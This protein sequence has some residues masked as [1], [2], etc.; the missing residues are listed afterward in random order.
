MATWPVSPNDSAESRG[1]HLILVGLPGAGKSAVGA[2]LA[3]LL[4]WQFVDLDR[5][6]EGRAG[7]AIAELFEKR[8]EAT[9]R[10]L[11]REATIEFASAPLPWV[12]APGGGWMA[13]GNH[14]LL[15]RSITVY[16]RVDPATA[17][18]RMGA[19][20]TRRPLLRGADPTGALSD[21]LAAREASY[22]Q[23]NH[24]VDV[25]SMTS[26]EAAEAIVPLAKG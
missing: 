19:G 3:R 13:Q 7:M 21:L 4:D 14:Q 11:E 15:P 22:L 5:L 8:G 23:A 20:I 25:D 24:T 1:R 16:L 9:F 2:R 12:I 10:A 18:S 6:I 26:D 17:V